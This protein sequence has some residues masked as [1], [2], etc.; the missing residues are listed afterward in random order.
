M[1]L[2][3]SPVRATGFMVDVY[4]TDADNNNVILAELNLFT[5]CQGPPPENAQE[6]SSW[7]L[8]A[9]EAPGDAGSDDLRTLALA[10]VPDFYRVRMEW[11]QSD[12]V[13]FDVPEG[14][15]A[16][17]FGDYVD[18]SIPIG[19]VETSVPMLQ[20]GAVF[21]KMCS[22][23]SAE[24]FG[25]T[26]WGVL[27]ADEPNRACGCNSG[28]W[29]GHGVYYG[30]W[31]QCNTCGCRSPNAF[32]GPKESGESK[33]GV[34]SLGLR[35][36]VKSEQ[37]WAL[38]EL[39][40]VVMETT[41]DLSDEAPQCVGNIHNLM[42]TAPIHTCQGEC[43]GECSG[44]VRFMFGQNDPDQTILVDLGQERFVNRIGAEFSITDREVWD[45]VAFEVS[46][47]NQDWYQFGRVGNDDDVPDI[48]SAEAWVSAGQAIKTRY[49]RFHFGDHS[50]DWGA[51]GSG[52]FRLHVQQV[53]ATP[54]EHLWPEPLV[55]VD[56]YEDDGEYI[57]VSGTA[58]VAGTV[59]GSPS[60]VAGPSGLLDAV[61]FDTGSWVQLGERGVDTDATWTIDCYIFSPMTIAPGRWGTLTRGNNGDHQIIVQNSGTELG[62]YENVGGRGFIGSGFDM[63]SL[64]D[65][66]HRLTAATLCEDG[67]C[68][69]RS[70]VFFIDGEEVARTDY[71]S[72]SDFY[73]FG[74]YQDGQQPW[75]GPLHHFRLYDGGFSPAD[76][77]GTDDADE[78]FLNAPQ[79]TMTTIS[80]TSRPTSAV[81]TRRSC[82][83]AFADQRENGDPL[84]FCAALCFE[85]EACS[86]FSSYPTDFRHPGR[87]C[88]YSSFQSG[89]AEETTVGG[90][91]GISRSGGASGGGG[92]GGN[93]ATVMA[94]IAAEGCDWDTFSD[95]LEAVDAACCAGGDSSCPDG[96]PTEC[97]FFCAEKYV[98]LYDRC[99]DLLVEM[100]GDQIAEF[101]GLV[102]TCLVSDADTIAAVFDALRNHQQC[103]YDTS[104]V[105]Q[106]SLRGG[107]APPPPGGGHRRAQFG[108]FGGH[109]RG[110]SAC[111]LREFDDRATLVD[112][113]CG[114]G[115]G[116][117][118]PTSCSTACAVELGPFYDDCRDLISRFLDDQMDM[119][120]RLHE[121]CGNRGTRAVLYMVE[122]L[123]CDSTAYIQTALGYS[124]AAP[125]AEFDAGHGETNTVPSCADACDDTDG[126]AAFGFNAGACDLLSDAAV[127]AADPDW[128]VHNMVATVPGSDGL[129]V[130]VDTP[131]SWDDAR[132][133]CQSHFY[134]L[135][136]VHTDLQQQ[137]VADLCSRSRLAGGCK[138]GLHDDARADVMIDLT[139]GEGGA[140]GETVYSNIPSLPALTVTSSS[141]VYANGNYYYIQYL[142]DGE[143]SSIDDHSHYFLAAN[144]NDLTF[145]FD[146]GEAPVDLTRVKLA[147]RVRSDSQAADF[148]LSADG[149]PVSPRVHSPDSPAGEMFEFPINREVT[150]LVLS[151]WHSSGSYLG[152]NEIQLYQ[153]D[154]D[155]I[156]HGKAPRYPEAWSDRT[157]TNLQIDRGAL[158]RDENPSPFIC[159]KR[160]P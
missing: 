151:V 7:I 114:M 8:I 88:F 24:K 38:E 154:A 36:Y 14:G 115:E 116:L 140:T 70:L 130:L 25:D 29:A 136:S 141:P 82:T 23:G 75:R 13:E 62:G 86:Y 69:A 22:S 67:G 155:A 12:F 77:Q 158:P 127:G 63:N 121:T 6:G 11:G 9:E 138:L 103:I 15:A 146:F 60:I 42:M 28:G 126:C 143:F 118:I 56:V 37:E 139:G 123:D 160:V 122:S 44:D 72:E 99:H 45:T 100:V 131:L 5:A 4:E 97:N 132:E 1:P 59:H 48:T 47:D 150:Q 21:C 33:G 119:F 145:T 64:S 90:F 50:S 2:R 95:R 54:V 107:G 102:D 46:I 142:F 55:A 31:D 83:N 149:E 120:D 157:P 98:P 112:A 156:A 152:F 34:P 27:P 128:L 93:W 111:P 96:I 19:N 147:P 92:G 39:G 125:L 73:A 87:C 58:G 43:E 85:D 40:A 124:E 101:D 108:G 51:A 74:N 80:T 148:Q 17:I 35:I 61:Q 26:C 32:S 159:E 117:A 94:H 18:P 109:S 52:I 49:V 30:G 20:N 91:Y 106:R 133:F 144:T 113:A 57:H 104:F 10:G 153:A 16:S 71:H 129:F 41:S 135:A 84:S 76:L 81:E 134:D 68:S 53:G 79:Y 110:N 105:D 89:S 137:S 65:G 78:Q 3:F 66:W